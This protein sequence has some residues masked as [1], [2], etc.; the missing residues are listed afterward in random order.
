MARKDIFSAQK[1]ITHFRIWKASKLD[2]GLRYF[3]V[4]SSCITARAQAPQWGLGDTY[5]LSSKDSPGQTPVSTI[6]AK[7]LPH[8]SRREATAVEVVWDGDNSQ[9]YLGAVVFTVGS[10]SNI[11]SPALS[12]GYVLLSWS[13]SICLASCF[14]CQTSAC[15]WEQAVIKPDLHPMEPFW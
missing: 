6:F 11:S 3:F 2:Q 8:F 14:P 12:W 4:A 15:R 13:V 10:A 1:M 5:P 9:L 7:D